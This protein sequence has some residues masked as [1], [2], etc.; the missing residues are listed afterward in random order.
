MDMDVYICM[1]V[2]YM[3]RCIIWPVYM[4]GCVM[5][6]H[7]ATLSQAL[8][9]LVAFSQISVHHL[10]DYS[11]YWFISLIVIPQANYKRV[12]LSQKSVLFSKRR[13]TLF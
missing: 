9:S 4:C 8:L 11:Y 13:V 6:I 1:C 12:I 5:E 2:V 7:V 10:L 3:E